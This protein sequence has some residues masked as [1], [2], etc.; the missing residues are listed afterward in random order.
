MGSVAGT[1]AVNEF[2]AVVAAGQGPF[3]PREDEKLGPDGLYHCAVC[4][5]LRQSRLNEEMTVRCVCRCQR[6]EDEREKL[7]LRRMEREEQRLLCF[8]GRRLRRSRLSDADPGAALEEVR[9]YLADWPAQKEKGRGLLFWGNV[10]TGKTFLAAALANE[11]IDAGV[12]VRLRSVPDLVE[13]ASASRSGTALVREL[14][15]CGLLVLDDLGA[16]RNTDY[17]QQIV[18]DLVNGRYADEKPLIVTTNLPL[19][20]FRQATDTTHRRIYSRVLGMCRPVKVTGP[21][22]RT[23]GSQE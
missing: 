5:E 10:G 21:D 12:S 7:R 23:A 22:R 8:P 14:C 15:A 2:L 19:S 4:G 6:E 16:E 17:A 1:A 11:L 13:E 9:Q 3:V 20:A 18:F